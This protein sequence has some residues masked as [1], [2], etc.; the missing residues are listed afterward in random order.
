PMALERVH[1][2]ILLPVMQTLFSESPGYPTTPAV[3]AASA[4]QE[5]QGAY[6]LS[7]DQRVAPAAKRAG[8]LA[9]ENNAAVRLGGECRTARANLLCWGFNTP[10]FS[11]GERYFLA[12]FRVST[13]IE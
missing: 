5:G 6:F 2:L 13:V 11:S 9:R 4:A 8:P 10:C 3:V 12:G 1:A 7:I